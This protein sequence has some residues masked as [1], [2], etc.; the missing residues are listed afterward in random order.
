MRLQQ[1]E[2]EAA[3]KRLEAAARAAAEERAAAAAQ[4]LE[5]SQRAV[6]RDLS[7]KVASLTKECAQLK[8]ER[9]VALVNSQP[10]WLMAGVLLLCHPFYTY[11]FQP[12]N[13]LPGEVD[14][15]LA[16]SG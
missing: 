7:V 12:C 14:R 9:D 13:L 1:Q 5:C 10:T 2:K 15:G 6:V 4:P 11:A 8:S 3:V 16:Y